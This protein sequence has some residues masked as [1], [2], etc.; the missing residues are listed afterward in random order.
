MP[1]LVISGVYDEATPLAVKPYLDRVPDVRWELFERSSHMPHVEEPE[2][3]LD[4][5]ERFLSRAT[6]LSRATSPGG[7]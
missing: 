6:A 4:V 7:R 3:Y 5:V 2:L 1:T